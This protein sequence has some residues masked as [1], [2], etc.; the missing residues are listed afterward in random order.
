MDKSD[1][2]AEQTGDPVTGRTEPTQPA[3]A[4]SNAQPAQVPADPGG[5]PPLVGPKPTQQSHRI[6]E[7]P[8]SSSHGF[9]I[10]VEA[11]PRGR[12]PRWDAARAKSIA[13]RAGKVAAIVFAAWFSVVLV[14][15]VLF[16]FVNPPFS[17]LMA[18]RWLGGTSISQQWEPL[19]R[20]SPN[21]VRAVIVSEDGRF[22]QH[23]GIDPAA[24]KEAIERSKGWTPRGASTITMQ[25]AKN[26]FLL[27]TKSYVRKALE[28]PLTFAIE[29]A[30][31]K[32]RILEVYLNVAEWG[33]GVFG[34]EAAAR[35]HFKRSAK[36]L[37]SYQAARL[38]VALPNPVLRSP[39]NPGP[40]T[41]RQSS[42]IRVRAARFRTATS[43]I[44]PPGG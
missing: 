40:W 23:W 17:T 35:K 20:I 11:K 21:L 42:R 39:R 36:S 31:P 18:L 9:E 30:W 12:L 41:A 2:S 24:I 19:E 33:Q 28:V 26:L 34:A 32:R 29:I 3:R 4:S 10:E 38:A 44:Y 13:I 25:V 43:C 8:P 27:P 14:L 22:C 1:S 5:M 15:I 7:D 16:R 37:N 6:E